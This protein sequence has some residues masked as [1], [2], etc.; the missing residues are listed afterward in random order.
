MSKRTS[1]GVTGGIGA[2]NKMEGRNGDLTIR[3]TRIGKIFYVKEN[4]QWHPLNTGIDVDRLRKDVNALLR[5][6]SF[7][8]DGS[9]NKKNIFGK[10]ESITINKTG[11]AATL[12]PKI[13][14]SIGGTDKFVMGVDDNDGDKF[15]IDAGTGTIGGATKLTMDSSGNVDLSASSFKLGTA[16]TGVLLK[17]NA[18]LLQIRNVGDS[19]DTYIQTT[20][21]KDSNGNINLLADKVSNAVNH[22]KSINSIT[23]L[24][25]TGPILTVDGTNNDTSLRLK[26][27]GNGIV[28]A[29]KATSGDAAENAT[30]L[31]V[32]FDRTVA[33]SGTNAHNDI[34]INLDVNSRSLGTSSV[35]GMDIDVVGHTDGTH[36]ATGIDIN[37][38]GADHNTGL[39]ITVQDAVNDQHIKLL[40]ADDTSDYATIR[41]ADTG[42]LKIATTGSGT[43]DSDLLLDVDGT[44]TLDSANGKFIVNE[45]GTEFSVPG[46]SYAGM[47]LGYTTIGIDSADDSYA[48]SNS[49]VVVS[50]NHKV[51]FVAPPSGAVEI[52]VFI[53]ADGG[54]G[55]PLFFG[56]SDA[57]ATTGYS[58]IDFPNSNDVT[59]EHE[60]LQVDET[61][62]VS[63]N[64]YWVVTG[65][66][67]GTAYEWWLGASC[68]HNSIYVLRWGGNVTAEYAPFIM[69][70]T[71]LPTAVTDY[72][73]YG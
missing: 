73:V 38:S 65:L 20:G 58:P 23:G 63:V 13:K 14:F 40:A 35:K 1:R 43:T 46:S 16:S 64:H 29:V 17:N 71:A 19:A 61:D 25:T 45:A 57:N 48:V 5:E 47:I 27:K 68:S 66:T 15:K 6:N 8:G 21:I 49:M 67:A 56:L 31:W 26:A 69:K 36:T 34:G 37:V 51:K 70:V 10:F 18:G 41:L 53:Q 42:D 72:A 3:K 9:N 28:T 59:N 30:G 32:D 39:S 2:P 11:S 62:E 52:Q 33:G 12:D 7:L 50:D 24:S 54:A 4:N 44:I 60:V 55:R 22:L